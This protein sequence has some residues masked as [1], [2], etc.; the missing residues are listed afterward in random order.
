MF[1]TRECDYAVRMI[2]AMAEDPRQSVNEICE[3]ESVTPPFAYKI[4]KKL[5]EAGIVKGFRGVHG[6]YTLSASLDEITLYDIYKAI[7]PN[8]FIIECLNPENRCER[9]G[10]D[11]K[12]CLVH[13]ELLEIQTEIGHL[14]RRKTIRQIL[15]EA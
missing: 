9:D 1:I 15:E 12:P 11:G 6:G 7:N 14:L 4:L 8:L 2:R 5:Q 3:K 13:R 10:A